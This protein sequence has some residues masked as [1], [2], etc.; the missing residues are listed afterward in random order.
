MHLEIEI[1]RELATTTDLNTKF[2]YLS[3]II[4]RRRN[5]IESIKD[6]Q[7]GWLCDRESIG[8]HVVSYFRG[9]FSS[10]FVGVDADLADLIQLAIFG[11]D[12]IRLCGLPS[13]E[14]IKDAIDQIGALKEPGPDGITAIFYQH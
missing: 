13:V 12:N 5:T 2:F 7:G 14:E 3:T 1:Q 10:E 11:D 6:G 4:R 8:A 9:L